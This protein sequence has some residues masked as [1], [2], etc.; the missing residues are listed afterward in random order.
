MIA[1]LVTLPLL[2]NSQ[3]EP[4]TPKQ[5]E[6]IQIDAESGE[7]DN[8]INAYKLFGN[9][10]ITHG[11]LT[12]TADEGFAYQTAGEDERVELFG[13]PTQWT[14]TMEDGS[15]A[16]GQSDQIVYNLSQNIITMIGNARVQDNRGTFTGARLTYNLET[17]KTEG[18][19]GVQVVIEPTK[20]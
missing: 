14:M 4:A 11:Q 19:G 10:R 2:A 5:N 7:Y 8:R 13:Q 6:P 18:E 12:V 3:T 20:P 16:T 1:L 9:V 17:E 15:Q